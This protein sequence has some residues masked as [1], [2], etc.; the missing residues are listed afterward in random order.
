MKVA[1]DAIEGTCY[2]CV[3]K[4]TDIPK[5]RKA[6]SSNKLRGWK[7]MNVFVDEEGNVYHKGK[8]QLELKGTLPQTEAKE[9]KKQLNKKEKEKV[10]RQAG[11][12]IEDLKKELKELNKIP[13]T[14]SKRRI[15][16]KRI[17]EV[18]KILNGNFKDYEKKLK[19]F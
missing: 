4:A 12:V 9:I 11:A 18:S 13:R 19:V 10:K 8:I 5:E 3:I 14:L 7:F 15:I 1:E 17:R 2:V 6:K 16:E